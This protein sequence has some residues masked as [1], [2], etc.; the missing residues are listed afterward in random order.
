MPRKKR[1][2][3]RGGKKPTPSDRPVSLRVLSDYLGL[4]PATLSLVLNASPVARSIPK[5]TKDRIFRA[6]KRFNYRPNFFARSL[7]AQRSYTI[8][9]VVP[10]VSEGY[11]AL[12]LSGIED[13]LL[14]AGYFYFVASHRHKPDLIDEYPRL[15]LERSVEGLI[16]V[17]TPCSRPLAVPVVAVSGEHDVE[18]VTRIRVNHRTAATLALAHLFKLG[19]R[20]IALIKGQTFSS[21]TEGRWKAICEAVHALGLEISPKVVAQLEGDTP[22]PQLG[23]VATQKI[24]AAR[25][26]FTALFAFNDVSA[27]GA[28]HALRQAGRRV[29]E[30]I[31]VV[32]FDDI[33][34]AAFQ[35]PS[36]TTIRQPL[37]KMG[38]L[39]AKT[40]LQRIANPAQKA[41]PKLL[42]VEPELIIRE[43]TGPAPL[44]GR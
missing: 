3:R 20:R 7:R 9:V 13:H 36:L 34:S 22:S 15:L 35:S 17:D 8:G 33:A 32:G 37:W 31:S 42:T 26:P 1:T 4:A 14:Q 28:I 6:A 24:L 10:E 43:S 30:D 2:N 41:P 39:A 27:I 40:V 23:Y 44:G 18:G 38:Q 16:A 11:E 12:V 19:H 29:P 21:D 5:E 25:Q